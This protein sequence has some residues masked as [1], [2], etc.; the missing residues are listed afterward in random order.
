M[1]AQNETLKV[2]RFENTFFKMLELLES[3]RNEV[4]CK[5]NDGGR[6]EGRHAI[7]SLYEIFTDSFLIRNHSGSRLSPPGFKEACK[8]LDGMSAEY[9]KF[10]IQHGDELG[11]YY[12]TLYNILKLVDRADFIDEK[13]I[14]TNLIRAQLSRYELLLLFYNCLGV[15]EKE[16]MAELVK[17]YK[18]L[19]YL[20]KSMLPK[21]N[22]KFWDDF[23]E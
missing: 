5:G 2:Q 3:C 15:Y 14:Y 13:A 6:I 21:E 19:K 12:R 18:I 1:Q 7:K 9:N 11:Q 10:Y 20:E 8:T 23:N 17:K 4:Y 22:Q 16:K